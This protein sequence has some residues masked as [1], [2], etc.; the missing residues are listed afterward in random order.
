MLVLKLSKVLSSSP[1]EEWAC[2]TTAARGSRMQFCELGAREFHHLTYKK[3]RD[4]Y[5]YS[6]VPAILW[7]K[8]LHGVT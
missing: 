7:M 2:R 1:E 3:C 4:N 5:L 8:E 6:L